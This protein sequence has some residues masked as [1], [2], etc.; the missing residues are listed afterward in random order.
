MK[1]GILN[2]AWTPK[3]NRQ[4]PVNEHDRK[5]VVEMISEASENCGQKFIHWP[6]FITTLI[7]V[8][9]LILGGTYYMTSD[10]VGAEV[11]AEYVQSQKK[12]E[13]ALS[14]EFCNLRTVVTL[15]YNEPLPK[16]RQMPLPECE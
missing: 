10:K 12:N 15:L 7:A 6:W 3:M 8:V 13:L 2:R 5:E 4:G 1:A 16:S 14:K 11:F 9:T